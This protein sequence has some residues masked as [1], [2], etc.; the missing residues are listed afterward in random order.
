LLLFFSAYTQAQNIQIIHTNDL[1]SYFN[2]PRDG[3]GGYAKLKTVVDKIRFNAIENG[4]EV[5]QVDGGDFGEGTSFYLSNEGED[6]L[7]ALD[8][9][10]V[11]VSVVGN[12]DFMLGGETLASQI[13]KSKIKTKIISANLVSTPGMNMGDSVTPYFDTIKNGVKIRVIGL[14]T[15]AAHFQFPLNPGHIDPYLKIANYQAKI[16]KESGIDL[17]I[18]LTHIGLGEDKKLAKYS[19]NIDLII[20]GHSHTALNKEIVI[21]NKDGVHVPIV[22]AGSNARY[23]GSLLIELTKDK[24]LKVVKYKLYPVN[25]ELVENEAMRL[26]VEKA[27]DNLSSYFDRDINEVIGE[28]KIELAGFKNGAMVLEKSCW[29]E[30]MARMQVQ[31]TG[32][33]IGLHLA[34]FEGDLIPVGDIKFID[35]I[36]NYPHLSNYGDNGWELTTFNIKGKY[37]KLLLNVLI[38]TP[39]SAGLNLSGIKY[40]SFT[41]FSR[42]PFLGGRKYIWNLRIDNKKIIGHKKYSFAMPLEVGHTIRSLVPKFLKSKIP[43][44]HHSNVFYWDVMETYIRENSPIECID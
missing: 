31:A 4:N 35:M 8:K 41:T 27:Y 29:G 40:K 19:Q 37:I 28:T 39:A 9:L 15:P 6:A 20:G 23:V 25:D 3:S 5:L 22:Q 44:F 32:A 2:G 10:G 26:F 14:T 17:V 30:H 18:A 21:H 11:D 13:I 36:D 43:F 38:N 24:K 12:H 33:D 42:I 16:A 1:H 34:N 7:L